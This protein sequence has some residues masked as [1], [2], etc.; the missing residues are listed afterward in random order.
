MAKIIFLDRDGT[1]NVRPPTRQYL[2]TPAEIEY[3][4]GVKEA[5]RV[6]AEDNFRFV[7]ATNQAGIATGAVTSEE[8]GVVN[9]AIQSDL[10]NA[11][12]PVL[13]WY[14]CPHRDEDK[15]LCRKPKPGL[16]L[17]AAKDLGL[18]L[19]ECWNVG[20][21]PRDI[22]M[23]IAAGCHRNVLVASGYNPRPD[24]LAAI[25]GTPLVE[26][27]ADVVNLITKTK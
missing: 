13:G 6:L 27:M 15:C 19:D 17:E 1:I 24:E 4:P 14:V 22:L 8:V 12:I 25:K 18:S 3:L 20:D 2:R 11:G 23:G 5:L 26:T 9:R 21:S 16:I 7:I 10:E